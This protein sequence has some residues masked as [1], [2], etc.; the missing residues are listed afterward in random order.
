VGIDVSNDQLDIA[1]RPE[2]TRWRVANDS[3]GIAQG[4]AQFRQ[5][6]PALI[7][8]EATG[9][10]QGSWVAALAAATRPVAVV[11]PRH[12]RDVAKATGPWAKTDALEGGARTRDGTGQPR[13][14]Y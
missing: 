3:A 6:K 2:H 12:I 13:A 11:N 10:W 9:G 8:L 1:C 14:T 4:L 5:L 7:V